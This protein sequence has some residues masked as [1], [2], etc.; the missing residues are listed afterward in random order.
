MPAL[1]RP[2]A[3]SRYRLVILFLSVWM[4]H[5]FDARGQYYL[6]GQDPAGINWK[7]IHTPHFRLIFPE[8]FTDRALYVADILEYS[9]EPVSASLGHLPRRVPVILNNRTV[10]P[11]GFVS[12]APSRI[13]MFSNPPAGN[14]PHGWLERLAVHEYRHVVQVDK[15]NQGAVGLASRIFGEHAT[16]LAT[17]L[18]TH[19][20]FLEGDAVAAETAFTHGGRGRLPSFER[21]LRAQVLEKEVYSYD[22]ATLG[23]FA[24]HVPNHYELGYQLTASGRI[25]YGKGIWDD[26]LDYI[27]RRPHTI[28]P[29]S[30]GLREH[31]GLSVR[32][33]YDSTISM[34]RSAWKRQYESHDY[35]PVQAINGEKEIYTHYRPMAFLDG[36]S[37]LALRS[38]LGDIP[39][40]ISLTDDGEEE[41]LFTPGPMH[42]D[43]FSLGDSLLAWT[44]IRQDPRWHHRS[45]SEV[46]TWDR[47]EQRAR[48]ITRRT[49]YFSAAV[50]PCDSM[51]AV[52]EVSADNTYSLVVIDAQSGKEQFRISDPGNAYIMHPE[53]HPGKDRIV[54][55]AQDEGGKRIVL[56]D[57]PAKSMHTVFDAGH[58]EISRPRFTDP[59]TI[60][61]NGAF[62]GIDNIY[63]LALP[64]GDV[65]KIVSSRFGAYDL[66]YDAGTGRYAWS[67]YTAT[68]FQA[69]LHE[70]KPGNGTPLPE[71]QNHAVNFYRRLVDQEDGT[72]VSESNIPRHDHEVSNY[73]RLLNLFRFHSWGPFT[74]DVASQDVMPGV[75][76]FSQN[77]LSTSLLSAGYE[78]DINERLGKYYA[79]FSYMGWYPVLDLRAETGLRRAYYIEENAEDELIPFLFR[80]RSL[81]AGFQVPLQFSRGAFLYGVNPAASVRMLAAGRDEETPVFFE[82]FR[83]YPLEYR[84]MAYWQQRRVP[85][86]LRPRWGQVLGMQYRHTPLREEDMGSVLSVRL[87][88]FFPGI[89]RHHSLRLSAGW[90]EQREGTAPLYRFPDLINYPRGFRSYYDKNLQ[91]LSADYAFPLLYPEWTVPYA[92]Y[93]KRLHL[94]IFGDYADASR[95]VVTEQGETD[96]MDVSMYSI[97]ADLVANMHILGIFTPVEMG[98][99]TIYMPEKEEWAFRLL[100]SVSL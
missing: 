43:R 85:R 61:F 80:E 86:D 16:G 38:G 7:Q 87:T 28:T 18:F 70:G 59:E 37:L 63:V 93:V 8:D 3:V 41:V 6:R 92:F 23:S 12:W 48:R 32:E 11:N 65:E 20:W 54:A 97:G 39:R 74:V 78:Y 90:Q 99:R 33:H 30:F 27:T 84:L 31:A 34:L 36:S 81:R 5:S 94:N 2:P 67:D 40:I 88:G 21:G 77:D 25:F 9:Y 15:L 49:R 26:V 68:G 42:G 72:V 56:A 62:S 98:L 64:G 55:V 96:T 52:A 53:W 51:I 13:E 83:I 45:W 35:T 22:K 1:T 17:G 60:V 76:V 75:S 10:V 79:D 46:Y 58:T 69:V 47:N 29:F 19:Q 66:L 71:I 24:D 73:S 95:F 82:G 91:V 89:A 50:S 100:F 57:I 44:E 14:D 4:L